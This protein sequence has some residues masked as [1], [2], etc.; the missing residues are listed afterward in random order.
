MFGQSAGSGGA[1]CAEGARSQSSCPAR[2]AGGKD[3]GACIL[4]Q[5]DLANTMNAMGTLAAGGMEMA[6][7]VMRAVSEQ[8]LGLQ[9]PRPGI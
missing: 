8:A 3:E 5:G 1:S 9:A 7:Q 4:S 2:S 6:S